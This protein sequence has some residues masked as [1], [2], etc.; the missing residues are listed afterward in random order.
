MAR[1]DYLIHDQWSRLWLV[2]QGDPAH[3]LLK[4]LTPVQRATATLPE[5]V[6][7]DGEVAGVDLELA[8]ARVRRLSNYL[9]QDQAAED[10]AEAEAGISNIILRQ[11][12]LVETLQALVGSVD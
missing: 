6:I 7:K 3:G 12:S 5:K 1:A 10:E 4:R 8:R 11:V 9:A 2:R